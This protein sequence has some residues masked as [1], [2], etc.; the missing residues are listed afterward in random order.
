[1]SMPLP[2]P[3]P[4][5]P[6]KPQAEAEAEAEAQR[7]LG[8]GEKINTAPCG[9]YCKPEPVMGGEAEPAMSVEERAAA[10]LELASIGGVDDAMSEDELALLESGEL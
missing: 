9:H 10:E 4:N 5:P 7:R 2:P 6:A 1:M 8:Q 3:N